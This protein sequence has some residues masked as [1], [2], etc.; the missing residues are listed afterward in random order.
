[1]KNLLIAFCTLSIM[2]VACKK[3]KTVTPTNSNP[4]IGSWTAYDT[5]TGISKTTI[6]FT[7][8][9]N[10]EKTVRVNNFPIAGATFI[11]PT[12]TTRF[13]LD[14]VTTT[15]PKYFYLSFVNMTSNNVRYFVFSK[16]GNSSPD[17]THQGTLRKN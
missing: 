9:A 4:Y 17:F 12:D 15:Y 2:V 14:S 10:T 16:D 1:M 5:V 11:I 8:T 6:N 7:I 13:N 3:E